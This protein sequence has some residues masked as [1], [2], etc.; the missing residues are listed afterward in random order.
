[1]SELSPLVIHM[2]FVSSCVE[3]AAR[4]ENTSYID[5]YHRMKKVGLVQAYLRELDPVHT[6]SREYVT[7]EVI[8]TL[9]ELESKGI[10]L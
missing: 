6:Q 9:H 7:N 2:A 1:M 5:M 3:S 10:T 8:Q 4:A